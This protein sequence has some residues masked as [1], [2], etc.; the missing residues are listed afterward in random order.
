MLQVAKI[1]LSWGWQKRTSNFLW[2][3]GRF[4]CELGSNISLISS[5]H[6]FTY[7]NLL[8][9]NVPANIVYQNSFRWIFSSWTTRHPQALNIILSQY[10]Q[11]AE[12]LRILCTP[13]GPN[14]FH[15]GILHLC[16]F[17]KKYCPH[18]NILFPHIIVCA[19]S[20]AYWSNSR[21]HYILYVSL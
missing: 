10:S 12:Y 7:L 1:F 11:V 21:H 2:I 6:G 3:R 4:P 13:I 5:I 16:L 8:W 9:F 20:R 19:F 18:I 17:S 15:L 14:I